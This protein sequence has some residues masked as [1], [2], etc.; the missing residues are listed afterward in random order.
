M[1]DELAALLHELATVLD[2]LVL[3]VRAAKAN[4]VRSVSLWGWV[5]PP[6]WAPDNTY[7]RAGYSWHQSCADSVLFLKSESPSRN[8][9]GS[10]D[11]NAMCQPD[12]NFP[13][14][15]PR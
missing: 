1:T 3:A 11:L 5:L 4:T 2:D 14:G 15:A 10:L 8:E 9:T 12:T 6:T 13:T 7:S